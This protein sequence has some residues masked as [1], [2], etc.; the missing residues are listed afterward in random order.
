[1]GSFRFHVAVSIDGYL[2]G[3]SQSLENPLGIGGEALHEWLFVLDVWRRLEGQEGGEVN[4]SSAVIEEAQANVGAY[5]MGRNMFG[6]GRGPWPEEPP[7]KGWW[8]DEPPYHTPVY[9]LTHHPREPL[10]MDGGTTFVFV[11]DGI[12]AALERARE[13]AGEKDVV[14]GGG[15]SVIQ[16]YLAAGSIDRFELHI[17]PIV[18]GAGERLLEHVG[19]LK[20]EQTRAIE[21]PGVTHVS[22]RVLR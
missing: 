4:A 6:G 13:A 9:V 17:A 15:A 12:R 3:P 2:A 10:E 1:M 5:V 11:T 8:G 22:Y 18:L 16:Q 19:D 20:L 14:L 21:A 7:W